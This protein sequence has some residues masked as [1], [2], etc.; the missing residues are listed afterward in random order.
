MKGQIKTPDP[1]DAIVGFFTMEGPAQGILASR[2]DAREEMEITIR[3]A[4]D[5]DPKISLAGLRHLRTILKDVATANGV[6]GSMSEVRESTGE[7]GS[8]V[9]QVVSTNKLISRIKEGRT[10][11]QNHNPEKGHLEHHSPQERSSEEPSSDRSRESSQVPDPTT[12]D[13]VWTASD[14][15][16]GNPEPDTDVGGDS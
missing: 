4:R 7:D 9:R 3:H 13:P 8:K 14:S 5:P 15:G 11:V 6:V 2:F 12:T 16:H 1:D 10:R